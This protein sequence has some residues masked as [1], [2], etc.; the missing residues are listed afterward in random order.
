MFVEADLGRLVQVF[1]NLLNNAAKYTAAGGHV[2]LTV[3]REGDWAVIAVRDDGAGIPEDMLAAIFEMFTQVDHSVARSHGGLGIGLT[4]VK[5]LVELHG[6]TVHAWS[7][8]P[9]R[10]S[11]FV[12]RLPTVPGDDASAE[13]SPACRAS[14]PAPPPHRVIVVDDVEPSANTMVLMLTALGQQAHAVYDGASALREVEALRPQL[15]LVDIAMPGMDGYEVARRVRAL[16]G[17]QPVLV[18]LTGYGQEDD[19]R[20]AFEAGFDHHL[21][22][23]TTVD[24]LHELLMTVP[25]ARA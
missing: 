7:D 12:V 23:P 18:A 25:A 1:G 5:S 4:L 2:W 3:K 21:V 8:G 24:A 6:G 13:A 22:K 16:P 11:E 17:R 19:R 14:L 9:G 10:G 15:A 20:R